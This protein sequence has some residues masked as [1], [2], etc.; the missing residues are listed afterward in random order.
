MKPFNL[1]NSN[2]R[3]GLIS[4]YLHWITAL[5]FLLALLLGWWM[6]DWDL[7]AD[8]LTQT[9][10]LIGLSVL[11]LGS[12]RIGTFALQTQPAALGHPPLWQETLKD[13]VQKALIALL[14]LIPLTGLLTLF[15]GESPTTLYG[16]SLPYDESRP[17][18]TDLFEEVHEIAS[19]LALFL[20]ALHALAA[21]KHHWFD[22]D[23][24]LK[25][26]LGR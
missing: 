8:F 15:W 5:L 13:W 11:F 10:Y 18:L 3:Y 2:D 22:L 19:N 24:T 25:R 1:F 16:W 23:N 14:V 17:F 21:L 20:I 9:H 12:L 7:L 6:E 26:M 4:I